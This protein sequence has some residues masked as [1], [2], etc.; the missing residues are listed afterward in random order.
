MTG[1][2]KEG[3]AEGET[4]TPV[5]VGRMVLLLAPVGKGATIDGTTV[6]ATGSS[7]YVDEAATGVVDDAASATA[8]D[9]TGTATWEELAGAATTLEEAG[10]VL[11]PVTGAPEMVPKVRSW[12][13]ASVPLAMSSG[14]GKG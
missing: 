8:L 9:G 2:V 7:T 6:V 4:G 11:P 13:V 10:F 3:R 5:P 1:G 12:G 14:P